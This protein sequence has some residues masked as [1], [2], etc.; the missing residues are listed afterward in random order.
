MS[1]VQTLTQPGS[2]G[3]AQ[4]EPEEWWTAGPFA[5][6]WSALTDVQREIFDEKCRRYN[7]VIVAMGGG[8]DPSQLSALRS[9]LVTATTWEAKRDSTTEYARR[10]LDRTDIWAFAVPPAL[11][12]LL[13]SSVPGWLKGV[14]LVSLAL[15]LG[16]DFEAVPGALLLVLPVTSIVVV[17]LPLD[18]WNILWRVLAVIAAWAISALIRWLNGLALR[19]FISYQVLSLI[20]LVDAILLSMSLASVG[21]V[22]HWLDWTPRWFDVPAEFSVAIVVGVASGAV[23][24]LW[25]VAIEAGNQVVFQQVEARKLKRIPE[26]EFVQSTLWALSDFH[27]SPESSWADSPGQRRVLAFNLQWLAQ[28]L[29]TDIPKHLSRLDKIH[30]TAIQEAFARR[31]MVFARWERHLLLGDETTGASIANDVWAAGVV[32]AGRRWIQLAEDDVQTSPEIPLL[33][34]LRDVAKRLLLLL[35]LSGVLVAMLISGHRE[36]VFTVAVIAGLVLLDTLSPGG[37][38]KLADA[39]GNA[40]RVLPSFGGSSSRSADGAA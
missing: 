8:L 24:G 34:R 9:D 19:R 27:E 25:S 14:L 30:A 26:E 13:I 18:G 21:A 39:A 6:S 11:T 31:A 7:N 23:L 36:A 12:L 1:T 35:V 28:L 29:R 3:E 4:H 22:P 20:A 2:P 15:F 38:G 40:N 33:H 32:G 37:G 17:V 16:C 5:T 10:L